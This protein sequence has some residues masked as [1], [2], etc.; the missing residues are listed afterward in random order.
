MSKK[1][2]N[3]AV[4][5]GG[6]IGELIV[7]LLSRNYA[8]S[9]YDVDLKRAKICAGKKAKAFKIDA[10]K[11]KELLSALKNK[12]LVINSCPHFMNL[13]I[14]NAAQKAGVSYIDLS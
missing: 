11:E 1:N 6:K 12:S 3:I 10:K 4:V 7:A 5:G 2:K 9:V 8:V 14:A 13:Y